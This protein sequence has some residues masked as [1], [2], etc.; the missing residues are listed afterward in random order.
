MW[1]LLWVENLFAYWQVIDRLLKLLLT[2][3]FPPDNVQQLYNLNIDS[4]DQAWAQRSCVINC[5]MWL[6]TQIKLRSTSWGMRYLMLYKS[7]INVGWR[8]CSCVLLELIFAGIKR[9]A[10]GITV[11][12][13]WQDNPVISCWQRMLICCAG[14]MLNGLETLNV[15]DAGWP[16]SAGVMEAQPI[17]TINDSGALVVNGGLFYCNL[18]K[19]RY[20]I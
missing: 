6:S 17:S 12:S 10:S 18:A 7:I 4:G 11:G 14:A 9:I 3:C 1:R 13:L 15:I 20:R 19:T 16:T 5:R 2:G 8:L